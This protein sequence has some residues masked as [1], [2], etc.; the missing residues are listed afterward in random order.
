MSDKLAAALHPGRGALVTSVPQSP[1]EVLAA[2]DEIARLKG[3]LDAV[4]AFA[5]KCLPRG[6]RDR[7]L[8]ILDG[9]S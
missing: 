5:D 1:A 6:S 4:R 2:A 3:V 8:S 7:L 9:S